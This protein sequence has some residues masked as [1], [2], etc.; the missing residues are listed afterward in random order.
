[1]DKNQLQNNQKKQKKLKQKKTKCLN[2]H[3]LLPLR[4]QP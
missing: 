1:M 3:R 2:C 4:T